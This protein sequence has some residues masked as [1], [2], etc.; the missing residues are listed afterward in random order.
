M[1]CNVIGL[2]NNTEPTTGP[3]SNTELYTVINPD[4]NVKKTSQHQRL[5][6]KNS[7]FIWPFIM[8]THNTIK[9]LGVAWL[10][11]LDSVTW[12]RGL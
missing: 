1:K 5:N 8:K 3:Y 6:V 10:Q 7:V 9:K 2:V 11:K 4:R 12:L